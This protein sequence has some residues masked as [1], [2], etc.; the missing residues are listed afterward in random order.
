MSRT[1]FALSLALVAVLPAPLAAGPP[2][3]P[4]GAMVLDEVSEGLR[5][6][7]KATTPQA[8]I[9]LL[10][11]LAPTHDPRVAVLLGELQERWHNAVV[12]EPA[13]DPGVAASILLGEYY[14]PTNRRGNCPVFDWWKENE[15][16]LR[17]RAKELP[18]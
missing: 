6:Y 2:D 9:G 5:K 17:R 7:R 3:A 15:T 13:P 18:R 14:V 16:D 10:R 11:K 4:R 12:D 8:R 1:L